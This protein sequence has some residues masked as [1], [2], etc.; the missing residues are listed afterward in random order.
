M[1]DLDKGDD[2]LGLSIFFGKCA[3]I[4]LN[5]H[6]RFFALIKMWTFSIFNF[7]EGCT[8]TGNHFMLRLTPAGTSIIST[9]SIIPYTLNKKMQ[10]SCGV[11]YS[12]ALSYQFQNTTFFVNI[13]K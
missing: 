13:L 2:F 11:P 1:E 9:Y 3:V 8:P 10:H 7:V 4:S 12:I 5:D 6:S